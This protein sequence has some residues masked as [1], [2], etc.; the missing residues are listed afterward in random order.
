MS[1][2]AAIQRRG[3]PAGARRSSVITHIVL[4]ILAVGMVYPLIWMVISSL[5]NNNEIFS[6]PSIFPSSVTFSNYVR[7][8]NALQY[9]FGR[10]L[11]NSLLITVGSIAGNLISCS[12]TAYAFAR[13][14]FRFK[15]LLMAVLLGTI[16]LP[17]HVTIV[18][19]YVI[20][21]AMGWI[22][23]YLPLIVPKFFGVEAFFVF[24]IIQFMRTI[25]RELDEAASIDG[26]GHFRI[27]SSIMLPL[28]LPA[29]AT[30]AIFSFIWTWNDFFRPLIFISTPS[31]DTAPLA[32]NLFIDP[33]GGVDWGAA[34]AM[35][36]ISLIPV[37]LFFV[38]GQR[39]LVQGISTTGLK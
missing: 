10:Y 28:I 35:S 23:T 3:T 22:N 34:F 2:G 20:F 32:L 21:A 8:W 9:P 37:L 33:T 16:M 11:L 15:P 1:I 25:P 24:L 29:L 39:F 4:L 30:T 17:E 38:F 6:D 18:P 12:L 27:F 36:V 26:C 19:Q 5:R 14:R 13:L 31:L 7:G